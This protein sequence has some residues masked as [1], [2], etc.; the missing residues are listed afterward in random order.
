MEK[1]LSDLLSWDQ[2]KENNHIK[3]TAEREKKIKE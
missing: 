3:I 1:L 2:E